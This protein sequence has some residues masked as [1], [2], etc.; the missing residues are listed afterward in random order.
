MMMLFVWLL[1]IQIST[2]APRY[3]SYCQSQLR[4]LSDYVTPSIQ[5]MRGERWD[6]LETVLAVQVDRNVG[7]LYDQRYTQMLRELLLDGRAEREQEVVC[8]MAQVCVDAIR[9]ETAHQY[10]SRNVVAIAGSISF[11]LAKDDGNND[12]SESLIN[13]IQVLWPEIPIT[14][15][16]RSDSSDDLRFVFT[17]TLSSSTSNNNDYFL[18]WLADNSGNHFILVQGG[19]N[20]Q[21]WIPPSNTLP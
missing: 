19:R 21:F 4:F 3:S 20:N 10:S 15:T 6:P 14:N 9:R 1:L 2:G 5:F 18:P 16:R 7:F 8:E 17:A 11:Y 12:Q 13:A